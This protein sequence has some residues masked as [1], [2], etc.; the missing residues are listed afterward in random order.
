MKGYGLAMERAVEGTGEGVRTGSAMRNREWPVK[1]IG[2]AEEGG[3]VGD[4]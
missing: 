4:R 1:G 3:G 2:Q